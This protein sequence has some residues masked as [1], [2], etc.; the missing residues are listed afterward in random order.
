M[1]DVTAYARNLLFQ[2]AFELIPDGRITVLDDGPSNWSVY[3]VPP[4]KSLGAFGTYAAI[5]AAVIIVFAKWRLR[6]LKIFPG[7]SESSK[8]PVVVESSLAGS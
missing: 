2:M 3:D 6:R 4:R 1:N 7:V 8:A 5:I